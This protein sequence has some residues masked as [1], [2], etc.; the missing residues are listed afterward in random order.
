MSRLPLRARLAYLEALESSRVGL[1]SM[2]LVAFKVPLCIPA[3][4]EGAELAMTGF[5]R[6]STAARRGSPGLLAIARPAAPR[7]LA[8]GAAQARGDGA[9][10]GAAQARG[11]GASDG[12]GAA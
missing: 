9:S 3:F 2:L 12:G 4:E 5:D 6:A 1:L 8:G 11:D 7:A 10:D